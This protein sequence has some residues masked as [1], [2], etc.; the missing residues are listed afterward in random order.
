MSETFFLRSL[1]AVVLAAAVFAST[2]ITTFAAPGRSLMGELI[3]AGGSA[4]FV[5]GEPANSGQTFFSSN[6]ITTAANANAIINLGLQGQIEVAPNSN[7]TLQFDENSISGA[8]SSG[9]VKVSRAAQVMVRITTAT[10]AVFA[11]QNNAKAFTVNFDGIKTK[12][13][14]ET[15]TLAISENGKLNEVSNRQDD[16]DD[17]NNNKKPVGSQTVVYAVLAGVAVG[18]VVLAVALGGQGG[19]NNSPPVVSPT[20]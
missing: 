10:G 12:A 16:D 18:A 4:V 14:S 2:S 8:L 1:T 19:S 9:R 6:T 7:L 5:N 13:F 17:D 20:R 3:V 15:G 11:N